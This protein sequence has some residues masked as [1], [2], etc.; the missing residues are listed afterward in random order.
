MG[1]AWTSADLCFDA[2]WSAHSHGR[3]GDA[4]L[5][6]IVVPQALNLGS[7]PVRQVSVGGAHSVALMHSSRGILSPLLA[8]LP[9]IFEVPAHSL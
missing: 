1:H 8:P 9:S 6:M 3:L 7:H 2:F 4:E 5:K